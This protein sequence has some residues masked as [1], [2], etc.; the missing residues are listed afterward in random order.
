M[1][2]FYFGIISAIVSSNAQ[3]EAYYGS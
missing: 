2:G 1:M 3:S